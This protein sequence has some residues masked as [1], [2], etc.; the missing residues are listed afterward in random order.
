MKHFEL[1][2]KIDRLI[3]FEGRDYHYFSGTAYLGIG[4]N[5]DFHSKVYEGM[6]RF[7]LN[8]GQSRGNNVRLKIYDDFESFFAERAGAES[9]IVMSSGY[10]AGSSALQ[11]CINSELIWVAPNTHPAILP[12]HL[13]PD[14]SQSFEVW[15]ESCLEES[16]RLSSQEILILGNAADPLTSTIHDYSW[17]KEIG[18]KHSVQLLIDDSHAFGIV[19][20]GIFGTYDTLKTLPVEVMVSGSLGKGLGLPAG[21]ILCSEERKSKIKKLRVYGGASPCPPAYL[22]AF[23]QSQ[24]IYF[25]QKEKL[26]QNLA[27]F[28]QLIQGI[29]GMKNTA[30]YPVFVFEEDGWVE[31]LEQ[32]GFI[33]SSFHYPTEKDPRINRIVISAFHKPEDLELLSDNLHKLA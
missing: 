22:F 17:L 23:L 18:E 33:I 32:A 31:A 14:S 16:R 10:L 24:D 27:S 28:S 19:S 8:H 9:G 5:P 21:I 15:K 2:Q 12:S 3:H 26:K 20:E 6:K 30:S 13:I 25:S 7:G 4:M 1:D 11:S 29:P